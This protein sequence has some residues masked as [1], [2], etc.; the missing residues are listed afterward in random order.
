LIDKRYL[1]ILIFAPLFLRW[2][3]NI[4]H[5]LTLLFTYT[6]TDIYREGKTKADSLS[7]AC[8]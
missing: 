5:I 7:K 8:L 6:I 4:K 1:G 3:M 2:L